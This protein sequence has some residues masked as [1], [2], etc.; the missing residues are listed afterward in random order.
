MVQIK[1]YKYKYISSTISF[2]FLSEVTL[3][4]LLYLRNKITTMKWTLYGTYCVCKAFNSQA[5]TE[6]QNPY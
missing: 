5:L 6:I 4:R 2:K 1:Y 3:G